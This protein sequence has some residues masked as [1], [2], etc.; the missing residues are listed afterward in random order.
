M[1]QILQLVQN[2][3]F[4]EFG[5]PFQRILLLFL[6]C[7]LFQAERPSAPPALGLTVLILAAAERTRNVLLLVL[8]TVE[9]VLISEIE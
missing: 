6:L 3:S 9:P 5:Q 8:A 2:T 1:L 7:F 4:F